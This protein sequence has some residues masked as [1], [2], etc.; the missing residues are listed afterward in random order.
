MKVCKEGYGLLC[1]AYRLGENK[2][3][4]QSE[5]LLTRIN[6][7]YGKLS[8]GQKRLAAYITDNYDKAVFLTAAKLGSEVGV[9]ESTTVRFGSTARIPGISGI[10]PCA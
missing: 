9:S 8:K 1:D 7:Q 4:E 10:P 5:N 2:S 3:M 6:Q